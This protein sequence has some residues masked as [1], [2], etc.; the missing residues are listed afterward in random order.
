M[1]YTSLRLSA[2]SIRIPI[3][4][5]P[6]IPAL[7]L[8]ISCHTTKP[9]AAAATIPVL[10]DSL[11]VLPMSEIDIPVRMAGAPFLQMA[12]SMVPK[13][14]LSAG[15]PAYLQP[16]C[17]FRYKYRF[18]RSGF[19]LG[20]QNNKF[21]LQMKGSYQVAGGK[22]VCAMNRPVSPWISGYCGFDKE[23]MRNVDIAMS[24]QLN[25]SPDYRIS[26]LSRVEQLK[27][28]DKCTMSLFSVDM[29][30][31]ILDSIRSSIN[32]FCTT[33]DGTTAGM[34]FSSF[35]HK[36][37][38]TW[39]KAPIGPYGYLALNPAAIRIGPINYIKDSFQIN[40]GVS[41]RPELTSDG[42]HRPSAPALPALS[43]QNTR[44]GVSLYLQ[45]VYDY[46]FIS[47]MLNDSARNKS[48]VFK[49]RTVIIKEVELKGIGHHQVEI[50][51]DFAGSKEGRIHLRGTPV[52]D[53]ARQ[54]LSIPDISYALESRDLV[55]KMAKSLL[56]NK[57]RHSLQGNSYLDLATVLKT[58]LP[59]L[60]AALNRQVAPHL[61][62]S[63]E[64]RQLKLIGLLVGEKNLE[65]QIFV[66]ANV[67][68]AGG[69]LPMS[70]ASH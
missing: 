4:F 53:T 58:N 56:K 55:L 17:D 40:L 67:A 33:L 27:A 41:C 57:I 29:T 45:A 25:I 21:Y 23:P 32:Y 46:P 7:L 15:W 42:G 61:Y 31:Q 5:F 44:H 36:S 16:S 48:F 47:K 10:P 1:N 54:S 6:A 24:C 30:Q 19:T 62:S 13:E 37:A 3:L 14:F 9:I 66:D 26:T 70:L 2:F 35:L 28:L 51:I 50:R 52:L 8:L 34:N 64:I 22:C 43:N 69:A 63:G 59:T 49:G 38:L 65:A 20:C 39:Q 12:D 11:P 60:N 68:V 18:V